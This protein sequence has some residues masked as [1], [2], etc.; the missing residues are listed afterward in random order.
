MLDM[1]VTA[2]NE[3]LT[4]AS[5]YRLELT[6]PMP[7]VPADGKTYPLILQ[8]VNN[9][10]QPRFLSKDIVVQLSS[11]NITVGY[12]EPT[13]V[14]KA[15]ESSRVVAFKSTFNIGYTNI[16]ASAGGLLSSTTTVRT[17]GISGAPAKLSAQVLPSRPLA[18]A[19]TKAIIVVEILDGNGLPARAAEDLNISLF[20]SKT[21]IG[22]T[23]STLTIRRNS[24]FGT[25][26]FYPTNQP[27]VTEVK[28][29]ASG[30]KST[31]IEVTT[32]AYNP[33]RLAVYLLPPILPK[34]SKGIL[35]VQIQDSYG[36]PQVA[37]KDVKVI[38]TSNDTNTA[39]L[40]ANFLIIPQ[41]M[42][43]GSA[44]IT[45]GNISGAA[46]IYAS[47]QGYR[48]SSSTLLV[49][50]IHE[51]RNG[52]LLLSSVPKL[53]ADGQVHTTVSV[54]MMDD[55]LT[56]PVRPSYPTQI[57]LTSSNTKIGVVSEIVLNKNGYVYANFTCNTSGNTTI[58]ATADNFDGDGGVVSVVERVNF[59]LNIQVC[60]SLIPID[61]PYKPIVLVEMQN[62]HGEP[63]EAPTD[64]EIKLYS[65]NTKVGYVEE[66]L[67][68]K[69]SESIGISFLNLSSE[70]GNTTLTAAAPN[71]IAASTSISTFRAGPST[72][73]LNIE[74]SITIADGSTIQNVFIML[75]DMFGY[76]AKALND[77]EIK[78]STSNEVIGTLPT[79]LT[80][81]KDNT[82]ITTWFTKSNIQGSTQITVHA[83]GLQS[84]T[85]TLS[86]ILLDLNQ[87]L[88][89]QTTKIY[90]NDKL[91]IY[92]SIQF[93]GYPVS[94]AD[95]EWSTTGNLLDVV[96]KSDAEGVA[97]AIFTSPIEG[98]YTVKAIVSK[99]GFKVT[100]SSIKV[101]VK[102]RSLYVEVKA[103]TEVRTF[104]ESE[105]SIKVLEDGRPIEGTAVN[106]KPSQG[107]LRILNNIT[108]AQGLAKAI[109]SCSEPLNAIIHYTVKKTG[110]VVY[111]GSLI[112]NVK[113]QPLTI[114]LN[115]NASVID[116]NNALEV[117]AS[118]TSKAGAVEGVKLNWNVI[119]GT[120]VTKS[121]V[122]DAQGR[123]RLILRGED[124]G[125]VSIDVT[126]A[127][128]GYSSTMASINVEIL[129]LPLYQ[130]IATFS[131]WQKNPLAASM[132]AVLAIV[133]VFLVRMLKK[134]ADATKQ[135]ELELIG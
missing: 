121:D 131:F 66:S 109:F 49:R 3:V 7:Y 1:N 59:K 6:L 88:F 110:Y 23:D 120:I 86:T 77:I 62:A 83:E 43:Y 40:D 133:C 87:T 44:E 111:N 102:P 12:T 31:S 75:Q 116:V 97:K 126:A 57:Y 22:I 90:A 64:V 13:A 79:S 74:P 34:Q 72:T 135:D 42:S 96:S 51:A 125:K 91:A 68:I 115:T 132:V 54:I 105:I 114:A 119:G 8:V 35:I 4:T 104:E 80:I 33:N 101:L 5:R 118:V 93:E 48:S 39:L 73:S 78:I 2:Q 95:V 46:T 21:S 18:K 37:T 30:L 85:K 92:S 41:G 63:T 19:G 113:P 69:K 89:A 65:S 84:S 50:E 103:P 60:P 82:W 29:V 17:V 112:I 9:D 61:S 38:L 47:A 36:R 128:K 106:F 15:G 98:E 123:G 26:Y 108:D 76:P 20:S 53:I 27:G 58:T 117:T 52:R 28:A 94:G 24:T 81:H 10:G 134:R 107:L 45:T 127:K 70:L 32:V 129:P 130:S 67:T 55:N 71:F 99:A 16:T 124:A 122:T 56:N 25:A 14:L 100:E 11:S